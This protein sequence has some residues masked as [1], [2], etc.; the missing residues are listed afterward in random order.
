MEEA[1]SKHIYKYKKEEVEKLMEEISSLQEKVEVGI[2]DKFT[3]QIGILEIKLKALML[4]GHNLIEKEDLCHL[5]SLKF[6][7]ITDNILIKE[8]Q[9]LTEK[10]NFVELECYGEMIINKISKILHGDAI[11]LK[12]SFSTDYSTVAKVIT[13]VLKNKD[14][15]FSFVDILNDKK[16]LRL[17]LAV[18]Q[19]NGIENYFKMCIE[20]M[21]KYNTVNFHERILDFEEILP[22]ETI[23]SMVY[24]NE[25]K[26]FDSLYEIYKILKKKQ[27]RSKHFKFPEGLRE[28]NGFYNRMSFENKQKF[29]KELLMD[30]KL[31]IKLRNLS[32]DC[33][34]EFPSSL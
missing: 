6:L 12:E 16:T 13:E 15:E 25:E 33:I 18:E 2:T 26:D 11:Y 28:I 5:Y 22:L 4:Y 7:A 24:Y 10:C 32:S 3:S 17:L 31:I 27:E 19:K 14:N 20:P 34:V 9:H 29:E 8:E 21:E 1:L 30:Q 23:Y